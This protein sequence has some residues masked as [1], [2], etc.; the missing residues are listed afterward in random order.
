VLKQLLVD[1]RGAG[2]LVVVTHAFTV[3]ALVGFLPMQAE[4][5]VVRPKPGDQPGVNFVGRI[6]APR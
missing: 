4:N 5:V 3:E 1:W 6:F 2:T